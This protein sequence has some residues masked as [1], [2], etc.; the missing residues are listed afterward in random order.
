MILPLCGSC[1]EAVLLLLDYCRIILA[2]NMTGAAGGGHVYLSR[3][4]DV[5]PGFI[6]GAH[7]AKA[8]A[9]VLPPDSLIFSFFIIFFIR[10]ITLCS[11]NNCLWF[12]YF[13]LSRYWHW[14]FLL[15][16]IYIYLWCICTNSNMRWSRG[17]PSKSNNLSFGKDK[18]QKEYLK[19]M[20]TLY[21]W[22]LGNY[23]KNS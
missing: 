3:A 18:Q 4:P 20:C 23:K 19:Y 5:T 22:A 13:E 6:V 14:H 8:L 9:F 2:G 17:F 12:L 15:M 11:Y 21:I 16:Y 7:I 1:K 10:F